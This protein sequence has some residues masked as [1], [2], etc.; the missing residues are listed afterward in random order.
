MKEEEK[1]VVRL[2]EKIMKG[3]E[4]QREKKNGE[5]RNKIMNKRQ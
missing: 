5:G 4:R 2:K 1:R 3:N